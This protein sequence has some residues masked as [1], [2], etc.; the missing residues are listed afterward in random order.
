MEKL[1]LAVI[2]CL[3]QAPLGGISILSHNMS[4]SHRV[5]RPVGRRGWQ[6]G[7]VSYIMKRT[8]PC[9]IQNCL[10]IP[11]A[12]VGHI[13]HEMG[14]AKGRGG[15]IERGSRDATFYRAKSFAVEKFGSHPHQIVGPAGC[16][17]LLDGMEQGQEGVS[18][19]TSQ[20]A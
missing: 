14:N 5:I 20:N 17:T 15:K 19:S 1:V 18:V 12:F 2:R 13:R 11:V 9:P 10:S 8:N 16:A 6:T 3:A 7:H 4:S